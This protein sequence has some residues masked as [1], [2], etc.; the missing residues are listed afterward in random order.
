MTKV[1]YVGCYTS[2]LTLVIKWYNR[3]R[4]HWY[5]APVESIAS[6]LDKLHQKGST[7]TRIK[8]LA[9]LFTNWRD[10]G[11]IRIHLIYLDFEV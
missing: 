1:I 7:L 4:S 2:P 3:G 11:D 5:W 9:S 8:S 10:E 6:R